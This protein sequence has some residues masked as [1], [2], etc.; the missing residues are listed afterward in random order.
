MEKHMP[1]PFWTLDVAVAKLEQLITPGVLGFYNELEATIIFA[2]P[3]GQN[4]PINIF[5]ILVAEERSGVSPQT[6]KYLSSSRIKLKGLRNWTFGVAQYTFPVSNLLSLIKGFC[7][8]GVWKPSGQPLQIAK[9][10]T[11]PIQFVPPDSTIETP[12]NRL[13]KNNFWNGSHIFEFSDEKKMALHPLYDDPRRLQELSSAVQECI[14]L[15]LA[16]LSD[17]LGNIIIQLPVNIV[18]SKFKLLNRSSDI[19]IE[20]AWHPQAVPRPLRAICEM[21]FDGVVTGYVSS[22]VKAPNT[23]LPIQSVQGLLR[24][25]IWDEK[26]DVI[27][28]ATNSTGFIS[29]LA[30]NVQTSDI[31]PRTFREKGKLECQIGLINQPIESR[32]GKTNIT[33]KWIERRMYNNDRLKAAAE[34]Y[35]VLYKPQ[36]GQQELCHRKALE[37]VRFLVRKYGQMGVW[38]WD[39]YL[40]AHDII[41]TLFHCP[42]KNSDLRA[43]TAAE[44]EPSKKRA[45]KATFIRQQRNILNGVVGNLRGLRLEYRIRMGLSG[46]NFHDRFLIFPQAQHGALV[47]SLGTSLN[48]LGRTHHILQQV[49]D[50]QLVMDAFTDLWDQLAESKCVI[51]KNT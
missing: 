27:L 5:S 38:L 14:P 51:W 3:P 41:E 46:G 28:V 36:N 37:D 11:I 18:A 21:Q 15:E 30:L 22:L 7:E 20:I 2:L 23:I 47:W 19:S 16:S 34:R 13:L 1:T 4:V 17:R 10:N 50:G 40:S 33:Q 35:F 32:V 24:G 26:H 43:L 49:D 48:D 29:S 39:P 31:E 44:I 42:H 45:D 25:A 8:T 9:L 12:L 6:F